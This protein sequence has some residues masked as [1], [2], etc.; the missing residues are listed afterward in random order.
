M[1]EEKSKSYGIKATFKKVTD[2]KDKKHFKRS[3]ETY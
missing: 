2:E 3:D 1:P